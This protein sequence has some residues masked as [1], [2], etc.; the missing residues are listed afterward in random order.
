MFV[1][2][3]VYDALLE[4][5]DKAMDYNRALVQQIVD[6]KRDNFTSA[7][8]RAP[9]AVIPPPQ[10]MEEIG[11]HGAL[12]EAIDHLAT[13]FER[14]GVTPDVARKE[15]RRLMRTTQPGFLVNEG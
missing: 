9:R 12:E 4:R 3:G 7:R 1:S 15:A 6:L 2:Q 5:Y 10:S 11:E 14:N 13:D 8:E